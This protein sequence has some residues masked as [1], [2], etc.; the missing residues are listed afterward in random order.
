MPEPEERREWQEREYEGPRTAVEEIVCGIWAEVL[1]L[2]RVGIGENFFE[3]GGIAAGDAGDLAGAAVFETEV[4]LA[5]IFEEPTVAGLAGAIVEAREGRE[6]GK[7][8]KEGGMGLGRSCGCRGRAC[9]RRRMRS[10]GCGSS[11][12]WSQGARPTT[13][14]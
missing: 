6:E 8:E 13:S 10:S 11:T 4:A 5:V 1:R 7:K 3:L 14:A 2:E 12:S 9:L